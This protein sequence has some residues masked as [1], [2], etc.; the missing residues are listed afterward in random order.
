MIS[1]T[2]L[3]VY[4][5]AERMDRGDTIVTLLEDYHYV[6]PEAFE[7]ARTDAAAHPPLGRRPSRGGTRRAEPVQQRA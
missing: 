3:G 2:R 6:P 4:G 1:G 5:I 7:T